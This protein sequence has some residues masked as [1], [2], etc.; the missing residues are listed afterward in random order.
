MTTPNL[1]LR[2]MTDGMLYQ[3]AS[4][5]HLQL[6]GWLLVDGFLIFLNIAVIRLMLTLIWFPH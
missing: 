3:E 5:L 2:E 1:T 6:L 4:W